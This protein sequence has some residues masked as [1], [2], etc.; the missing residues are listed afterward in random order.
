[1]LLSDSDDRTYA[2]IAVAGHPRPILVRDGEPRPVG[3]TS[4]VLGAADDADYLEDRIEIQPDDCLVLYTDGVLDAAGDS[5]RFGEERLMQALAGDA[6]TPDARLERLTAALAAFQTGV[7]RDDI[8]VLAAQ[9]TSSA[10]VG[11]PAAGDLRVPS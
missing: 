6:S 1:V 8:A 9:R 4:L 5:D 11:A 7:Q 10:G 2:T 3:R